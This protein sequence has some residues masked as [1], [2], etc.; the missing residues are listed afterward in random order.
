[1]Q[2]VD[3]R[4]SLPSLTRLMGHRIAIPLAIA[5]AVAARLALPPAADGTADATTDPAAFAR[6]LPPGSVDVLPQR[7]TQPPRARPGLPE[8]LALMVDPVSVTRLPFV[9]D[10]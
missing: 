4:G 2:I 10:R 6:A 8:G 5:L 1:M 3:H 9:P 7:A